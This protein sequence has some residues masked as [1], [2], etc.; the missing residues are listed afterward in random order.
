[1]QW[2][3]K[4]I[5]VTMLVALWITTVQAQELTERLHWKNGDILPGKLMESDS[6]TVCWASEYFSDNLVVDINVLDS[7]LFRKQSTPPTETFQINTASDDVW[8]TDLIGADD[9]TFLFSSKRH[10]QVRVNRDAIYTL[11]RRES[12]NLIFN[13]SQ[14]M[15]WES[16]KADESKVPF[17]LDID[18]RTSWV[19][20]AAGHLQTSHAKASIFCAFHL[21]ERFEIDLEFTSTDEPP[22]FVLAIGESIRKALR[23]ETWADEVVIIQDVRFMRV[24]TFGRHQRSIRLR[25]MFD[26]V[27]GTLNVLDATG[28]L[29]VNLQDVQPITA[30][31]GIF[32]RNRGKNLTVRQLS[33]YRQPIPLCED[34][35]RGGIEG[36]RQP[37][38]P[39]KPRVYMI[40]GQVVYGHLFVSE[41]TAY[42]LYA[43]GNRRNIDLAE[44]DRVIQPKVEPLAVSES[45]AELTYADGS[46]LRGKVEQLEADRVILRT[47]F[48]D[49]PVTCMLAGASQF[50]LGQAAE[51][52]NPSKGDDHL[53]YP[54]GSLRGS[55]SFDGKDAS[56]ILWQSV[57][58]KTPVGLA[59]TGASGIER[60]S[61]RVSQRSLFDKERFPNML[62]LKN[63]EVIPCQVSSYDERIF[64]F[65]AP[66]ITEKKIDSPFVK[67][68]EFKP[69]ERPNLKE[70]P[71]TELDRWLNEIR[72]VKQKSVLGI[73]SVKLERALTVPRFNRDNPPSH[74]LV[75]N[76]G[77]FKRGKLLGINGQTI[78]FDSK[79]RK[80][81][82]PIN[83][84]A[85]VVDVSK[86]RSNQEP[87]YA[88]PEEQ[89]NEPVAINDASDLVR[90]TLADR[91]IL[92]FEPLRSED[93]MLLGH[94]PI[95]GAVAVPMNS[96]HY[97]HFGGYKGE[98]L[99]PVFE[100]WVVQPS[101]EPEFGSNQQ[102]MNDI[103][104]RKIR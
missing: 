69:S 97:L 81:A 31:S 25:L 3:R 102:Y 52:H 87:R 1:M 32:I 67:A 63:G 48:A 84:V 38:D 27:D 15:A 12:P 40:D 4:W 2:K 103:Q 95:Y 41:G 16:F 23:L 83:R 54:L 65:Q 71:S 33:V 39:S 98:S 82:I 46:V 24:L 68:I 85:R 53:F 5:V 42:V 35:R 96:I 37:I 36:T 10:G 19:P 93:G 14:P 100:E 59:Y 47:T 9:N 76:T 75:A 57:G 28:H 20:N 74:L 66:F 88:G 58:A 55:V 49:E 17:L 77:D 89:P 13:G 56:P 101:K 79:L 18:R 11:N 91:S 45:T 7:I 64:S 70:E 92:V 86:S 44:V 60:D 34:P 29:L 78:Q 50:R 73:D 72:E 51:T 8:T 104:L 94:S 62:H 30:K 90:I 26:G 21:P 61:K 80:L 22:G 6:G 99:K 43:R